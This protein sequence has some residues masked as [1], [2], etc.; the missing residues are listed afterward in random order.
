MVMRI[1]ID[2][3]E[4]TKEEIKKIIKMLSSLVG[5]SYDDNKDIFSNDSAETPKR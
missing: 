2:T 3:K 5:N 1:T 4:D